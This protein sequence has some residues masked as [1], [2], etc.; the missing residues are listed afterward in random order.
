MKIKACL[1]VV[2]CL[3]F[4]ISGCSTFRAI[5]LVKGGEVLSTAKE[6]SDLQSQFRGHMILVKGKVNGSDRNYT[7]ILD[8]AALTIID[9]KVASE[10]GLSKEVEVE[11]ND[12]TG[13]TKKAHLT[14]LDTLSLG[15]F[16]VKNPAAVIMDMARIRQMEGIGVDGIVGSN[17]LRFFKVKIDY[18]RPHV[19]LSGDTT[20]LNIVS[21]GCLV[22]FEQLIKQGF[23]PMVAVAS[24]DVT[25]NAVVDTGLAEAL[26]LP[27]PLLEKAG[28]DGMIE[29][30]G[31]MGGGAFEDN[32]KS[33]LARLNSFR[34]GNTE[35]G[36]V[37]AAATERSKL[38]LIGTEFLSRF[39]VTLN[40]PAGEM[41]LVPSDG[42]KP[43]DNVFTT[44]IG[45]VR[46][47]SGK[48]LVSGVWSGSPADRLGIMARDE[49]AAINGKPA[50]DYTLH[51][52]REILKQDDGIEA[53]D[54]VIRN[55]Q[56]EKRL[57]IRKEYLFEA[58]KK[59]QST[60]S[61]QVGN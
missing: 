15:E 40:Y 56:G 2:L 49:I 35:F 20:P 7:F 54:L 19:T 57:T 50:S 25:F 41:L 53:V 32:N 45:V 23:A 46:D 16:T 26:S 59:S 22:K 38:P 48:A 31:V 12:N 28:K 44:G 21:G 6:E 4:L 52:L 30:K 39:V 51:G 61:Q 18:Q 58:S 27:I 8:T 36:K 29:G 55:S 60:K 42:E 9:E 3:V 33:R 10:L 17:V 5:S 34:V 1:P 47:A 13:R 11:A 14:R 24:G 37:V 43:R